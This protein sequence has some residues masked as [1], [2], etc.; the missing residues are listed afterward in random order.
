MLG[1][2]NL[3]FQTLVSHC[4]LLTIP[5][6]SSSKHFV[7]LTGTSPLSICNLVVRIN[8]EF[9]TSPKELYCKFI[10]SPSFLTSPA[11]FISSMPAPLALAV[12]HT[13][14]SPL[15]RVAKCIQGNGQNVL[16]VD[17]LISRFSKVSVAAGPCTSN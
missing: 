14:T 4:R 1:I 11:S 16:L 7:Q 15:G 3:S 6:D 12:Q 5:L 2:S 17:N 8:F 9:H 13:R 10:I